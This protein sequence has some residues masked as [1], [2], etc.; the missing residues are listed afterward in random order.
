MYLSMNFTSNYL[1]LLYKYI[2]LNIYIKTLHISM[3]KLVIAGPINK[4][5]AIQSSK[6]VL[7]AP[8]QAS[9][10]KPGAK[11]LYHACTTT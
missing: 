1:L 10:I 8:N 4:S 5:N 2:Y 7:G 11:R 9:Y 6:S 3:K